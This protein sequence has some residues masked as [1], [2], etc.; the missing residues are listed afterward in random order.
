V[1]RRPWPWSS[2]SPAPCSAASRTS[3]LAG[4]QRDAGD[5]TFPLVIVIAGYCTTPAH[6]GALVI[7][8]PAGRGRRGST[9]SRRCRSPPDFVLAA[10][11]GRG[12]A[13]SSA[14]RSFPPRAA[15]RRAVL[16]VSSTRDDAGRPRLPRAR[17]GQRMDLGIDALL[18]QRRQRSSST[19][20][21]FVPPASASRCSAP[22]WSAQL[23][24][25][26]LR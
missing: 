2:A 10:R 15:D 16:R 11:D 13:G 8:S 17:L 7:A 4:H 21:W 14:S 18:V 26:S 5:P 22:R 24:G 1:S 19:W 12:V 6:R 23:D 25:R 20:W 3:A 9:G